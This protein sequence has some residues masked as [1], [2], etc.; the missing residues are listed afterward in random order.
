MSATYTSDYFVMP[1][2]WWYDEEKAARL[3]ESE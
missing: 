3:N 2:T 1:Y